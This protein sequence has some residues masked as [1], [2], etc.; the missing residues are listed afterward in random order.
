MAEWSKANRDCQTVIIVH[1][2]K[3]VH[4]TLTTE[5]DLLRHYQQHL[6]T[7]SAPMAEWSKANRDWQTVIIVHA[8]KEVH[9]TL[10]TETGLLRHY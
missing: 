6:I 4:Y 3:E 5:N 10:T 9:Y 2:I 8:I 7:G 1:A